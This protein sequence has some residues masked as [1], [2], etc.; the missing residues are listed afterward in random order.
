MHTLRGLFDRISGGGPLDKNDIKAYLEALGAGKGILGNAKIAAAAQLFMS[1]FDKDPKDG[2]ISWQELLDNAQ[3][4]IP[5]ALIS[6]E[7]VIDVSQAG[8]EFQAYAK[9]QPAVGYDEMTGYVHAKL[10][11]VIP[12]NLADALARFGM[13]ALDGD[14]DGRIAWKDIES[15]IDQYNRE[16]Q[17][18]KSASSAERDQPRVELGDVR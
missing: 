4:L 12:G 13:D 3:K 8:R 17:P 7:G 6:K 5:Q 9:G 2:G 10:P 15:A 14:N 18:P 11:S 16:I 1:R